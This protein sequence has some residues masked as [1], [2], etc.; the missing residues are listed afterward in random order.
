MAARGIPSWQ[1]NLSAV[2]SAPQTCTAQDT[3]QPQK[4]AGRGHCSP[5]M[6]ILKINS[7]KNKVAVS[8]P[9]YSDQLW[10]LILNHRIKEVGTIFEKPLQDLPPDSSAPA[11]RK[12]HIIS[13]CIVLFPF[14]E[15]QLRV[16]RDQVLC[17]SGMVSMHY[18][19]KTFYHFLPCKWW[20]VVYHLHYWSKQ[21][22]H[23]CIFNMIPKINSLYF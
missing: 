22:V 14:L 4:P 23:S 3:S 10:W 6:N 5:K 20:W 18:W 13:L 17:L 16:P 8:M 19:E 1:H 21:V 12:G 9:K 7:F 15:Q 11:F 2:P